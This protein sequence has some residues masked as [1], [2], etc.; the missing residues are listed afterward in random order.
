MIRIFWW[1]KGARPWNF[2]I[3][4]TPPFDVVV[5]VDGDVKSEEKKSYME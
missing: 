5:V 2:I 4:S 1:E 3:L